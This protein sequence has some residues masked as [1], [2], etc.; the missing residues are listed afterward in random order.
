MKMKKKILIISNLPIKDVNA[1]PAIRCINIA[2]VLN[3]KYDCKLYAKECSDIQ[4]QKNSFLIDGNIFKIIK[5][6]INADIIF[7]QPSRFKYLFLSRLFN[8]KII[9]DLYDPTDLEN[10]EMYKECSDLKSRMIL[11]YSNLRLKYS[12][13]IGDYFVCAS[14]KQRDYWIG[15][16]QAMR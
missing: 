2:K 10:L 1:G 16:L 13:L 7:S 4:K 12:I 3:K 14:E 5:E 6:F 11:K 9:I 15:Y 8:K